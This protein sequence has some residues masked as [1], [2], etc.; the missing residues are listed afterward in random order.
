MNI[1]QTDKN[2]IGLTLRLS[3]GYDICSIAQGFGFDLLEVPILMG[4]GKLQVIMVTPG[5]YKTQPGNH[6]ANR[7]A[8]P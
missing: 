4:Q 6:T 8:L 3:D 7:N 2:M 5:L 1:A